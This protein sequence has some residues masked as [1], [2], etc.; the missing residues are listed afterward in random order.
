MT[1]GAITVEGV[2]HI[3]DFPVFGDLLEALPPGIHGDDIEA[4][5]SQLSENQTGPVLHFDSISAISA[6]A[7][8]RSAHA[9]WLRHAVQLR[10]SAADPSDDGTFTIFARNIVTPTP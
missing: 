9:E 10:P 1:S 7:F 2:T 4:Q 6:S 3:V 5:V 8:E